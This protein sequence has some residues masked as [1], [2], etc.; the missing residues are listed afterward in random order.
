MKKNEVKYQ[1]DIAFKKQKLLEIE[2]EKTEKERENKALLEHQLKLQNILLSNIKIHKTNSVKRP[3]VW[4]DGSYQTIDKQY[5]AFF[6]ELKT[7][8]DMEFNNFTL[9]LK[10]KFSNLSERDIQFCCLLLANF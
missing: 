3:N 5:E 6:N 2:Q 10:E 8:I 9:R 4:K 7:Y 1:K